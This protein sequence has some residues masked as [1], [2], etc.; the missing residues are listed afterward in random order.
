[1]KAEDVL[2]KLLDDDEVAAHAIEALCRMKSKKAREK[3]L[4]LINHPKAL[5]KKEA[6]KALK[7]LL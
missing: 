3:I 2:I 7:K 1:M 4:T 5:I 6:Q